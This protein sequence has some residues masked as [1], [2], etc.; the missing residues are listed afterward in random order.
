VT[1]NI[2]PQTIAQ[3][4]RVA[5]WLRQQNLVHIHIMVDHNHLTPNPKTRIIGRSIR[6]REK[7]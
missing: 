5:T 4:I 6:L 7:P 3:E 1:V 2:K